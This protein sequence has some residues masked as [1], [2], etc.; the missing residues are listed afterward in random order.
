M[1]G[2]IILAA[3]FLLFA[4]PAR[5]QAPAP[6]PEAQTVAVDFQ[7]LAQALHVLI[8]AQQRQAQEIALLRQHQ[9]ELEAWWRDYVAKLMLGTER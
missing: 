2:R 3:A 7:N 9:A 6:T 1:R 4:T 8:A 5:A